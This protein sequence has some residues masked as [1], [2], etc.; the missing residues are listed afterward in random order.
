M[1]FVGTPG[2]AVNLSGALVVLSNFVSNGCNFTI[3][4][5][6]TVVAGKITLDPETVLFLQ[7]VPGG[8][9]PFTTTG[10]MSFAGNYGRKNKFF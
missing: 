2:S 7:Q 6:G 3:N 10:E 4:V 5:N 1:Q 9:S 8:V